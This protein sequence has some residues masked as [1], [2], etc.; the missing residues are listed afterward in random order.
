MGSEVDAAQKAAASSAADSDAP[1]IFDKVIAKQIPAQIIYE[2]EQALAFRDISP[3]GPVHFLV[4]PKVRGRLTQL[5]KATEEDKPLLGHLM[6]VAAQVAKQ[7]GL[8]QGYRVC[9]NDGPNGCQSVYHMHLHIIGGRQIPDGRLVCVSQGAS[10]GGAAAAPEPAADAAGI[11]ASQLPD[12]RR[13][14]SCTAPL[15]RH[16]AAPGAQRAREQQQPKL[17]Q[18]RLCQHPRH[19]PVDPPWVL[20][21]SLLE[22]YLTMAALMCGDEMAESAFEDACEYLDACKQ[23]VDQRQLPTRAADRR[24]L[25][26]DLAQV[27]E[28]LEEQEM[29]LAQELAGRSGGLPPPFPGGVPFEADSFLSQEAALLQASACCAVSAGTSMLLAALGTP[30][31][32]ARS[33]ATATAALAAMGVPLGAVTA[34]LPPGDTLSWLADVAR[35][36]VANGVCP[37][38]S[39]CLAVI[40]CVF[41]TDAFHATEWGSRPADTAPLVARLAAGGQQAGQQQQQ[42]QHGEENRPA[43]AQAS[44]GPGQQGQAGAGAAVCT[45]PLCHS[46]CAERLGTPGSLRHLLEPTPAAVDEPRNEEQQQ[47]EEGSEDSEEEGSEE[48][49]GAGFASQYWYDGERWGPPSLQ[50]LAEEQALSLVQSASR[51]LVAA[52]SVGG[53][54]GSLPVDLAVQ[55]EAG[56]S[57]AAVLRFPAGGQAAVAALQALCAPASFGKGGDAVLD[58]SY[59]RALALPADRLICGYKLAQHASMLDAVRSRMLPDV[60]ASRLSARLHALNVYTPGGFFRPHRDTP[61]GGGLVGSLLV[62][63]PVGHSGGQL[64]VQH[65]GCAVVYDWGASAAAGEVQWA[66]F[67]PDCLHEVLP[68]TEGARVTLAYELFVSPDATPERPLMVALSSTGGLLP[69]LSA[70]LDCPGF[71]DN[72]GRLGFPCHHAYPNSLYE[73]VTQQAV[74]PMLL[75]EDRALAEALDALGVPFKIVRIWKSKAEAESRYWDMSEEDIEAYEKALFVSGLGPAYFDAL[76]E[77]GA[78]HDG[79]VLQWIEDVPGAEKDTSIVWLGDQDSISQ[80]MLGGSQRYPR[81]YGRYPTVPEEMYCALGIVARVP[82]YLKRTGSAV[83]LGGVGVE[84]AAGSADASPG[85]SPLRKRA[86]PAGIA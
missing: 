26:K 49:A 53:S 23:A 9:I 45:E 52:F 29:A 82:P 72:G 6:Y 86:K 62:C 24:R 81:R 38:I 28:R 36:L 11:A 44:A 50:S 65:D 71:L 33:H 54:L 64:R 32:E 39:Q 74:R 68:V 7:E 83:R 16:A 27:A 18:Q 46:S 1:T 25:L 35:W 67:Y 56:G 4:I 85:R 73:G 63:L 12:A 13:L 66:A 40:A 19:P 76:R 15:P 10:G 48:D 43:Q 34:A 21:E 17:W 30:L 47:E 42:Q 37:G 80:W 51:G 14:C 41:C 5:S 2:D 59:R 20:R 79:G 77:E 57:E 60:A 22:R 75:G 70:T 58:D 55:L 31:A 84:G 3:Q 61:R 8:A 69:L 78:Y